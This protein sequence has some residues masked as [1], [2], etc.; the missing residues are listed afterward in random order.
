MKLPS[1]HPHIPK[2]KVG[3]LLINLGTPDRT[4]YFSM[5]RYLNEFLSDKRVIEVPAFLWQPILK[6]IILTV[7]P[8][9]SGKLYDKIWNKKQ[10]ESPLRTNTRLQAEQLSQSSHRNVVVEWAMRYG[11]PSIKD[12]INILLEKGCTKILFFP[13]YPQYSATTTASVM[14]KIY[15]ALKFIRWQPSIRMVPPFYD[16]RIYIETIVE[17]IQ[18]HI[19]KLN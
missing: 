6:L 5:R 4:D 17:S 10:N 19:K 16:E 11:N 18:S 2:P 7:R 14:D 1:E 13:L 15:E 9:K 3:V 12:K 8:K